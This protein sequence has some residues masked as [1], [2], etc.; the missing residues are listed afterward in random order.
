M[1]S[2]GNAG[3]AD[4]TPSAHGS[5][6][7]ADATASANDSAHGGSYQSGD[8]RSNRCSDNRR[9]CRADEGSDCSA[10]AAT[11]VAAASPSACGW[12]AWFFDEPHRHVLR[13]LR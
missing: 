8:D 10:D 5:A 3:A 1:R 11:H 2:G 4:S 13:A 12:A 7:A 6:R 9:H